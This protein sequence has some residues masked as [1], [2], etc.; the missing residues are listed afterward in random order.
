MNR[1]LKI[2]S[3]EQIFHFQEIKKKRVDEA[4]FEIVFHSIIVGISFLKN[5]VTKKYNIIL[6]FESKSLQVFEFEV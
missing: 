1:V 6:A 5:R 3:L 2:F 4:S